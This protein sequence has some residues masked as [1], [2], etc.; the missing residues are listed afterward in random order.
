MVKSMARRVRV[1]G[2]VDVVQVSDPQEIRSLAEQPFL[3]RNFVVRGPLIN[4]LVIGKIR[5]WFR[6]GEQ[7][8][9]VLAPRDD[10]GR[11]GRQQE[12][13]AMLSGSQPSEPWADEQVAILA[14][15]VC[16]RGR[17][18]EAAILVQQIIGCRFVPTYRSDQASW[19]AASKIDQFRDGLSAKTIIWQLTGRLRRAFDLLRARAKDD[20]WC[21]HGTAIGLHGVVAALSRMRQ[22]RAAP[23]LSALSDE[24]AVRRCIAAPKQVPRTV[25]TEVQTPIVDQPLSAGTLVVLQLEAAHAKAPGEEMAFMHGHWSECPAREFVTSLLLAVWRKSMQKTATV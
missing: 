24:A 11:C 9:P 15:Y 2:L 10:L 13:A 7:F 12:L 8:L 22:L 16:G 3:D 14:D 20:P 17:D 19:E 23:D 21:F 6:F 1:P 4:R 25:E 18:D 5:R